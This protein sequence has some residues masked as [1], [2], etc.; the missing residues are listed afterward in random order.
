MTQRRK[1]GRSVKDSYKILP[2]IGT[3]ACEMAEDSRILARIKS[4]KQGRA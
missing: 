1:K 2:E 3:F 4:Q